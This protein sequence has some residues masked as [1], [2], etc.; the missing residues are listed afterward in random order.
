MTLERFGSVTIK[1]KD[2]SSK[3]IRRRMQ[4][5]GEIIDSDFCESEIRNCLVYSVKIVG[6]RF[7]GASFEKV[8]F[9]NCD[10]EESN[11]LGATFQD[12]TFEGCR[13]YLNSFAKAHLFNVE[14]IDCDRQMN[15]YS[16]LSYKLVHGAK[17]KEVRDS[18]GIL[19]IYSVE[20]HSVHHVLV[21]GK[22]EM[23]VKH[24]WEANFRGVKQKR[25]DELEKL[26]IEISGIKIG[27]GV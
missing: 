14:F 11:F 13:I 15:G 1:D 6:T 20:E 16:E 25:L 4:L 5:G 17:F 7:V 19:L 2:H 3:Q 8:R 21:A 26:I 10:I 18:A 12:C 9:V 22:P 23:A 24:L 27:R